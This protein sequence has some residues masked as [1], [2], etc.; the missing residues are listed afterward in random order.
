MESIAKKYAF[1]L[2]T[3]TVKPLKEKTFTC[4]NTDTIKLE[5][6]VME[7][8]DYKYLDEFETKVEV[9]YSYP[10]G[11]IE[12]PIKQTMDEGGIEII[13]DS[14]ITIVPAE[15]CLFPTDYLRI[16]INVYNE[17]EFISLQPFIFRVSKSKEG[18]IFDEAQDVL[19]NVNDIRKEMLA[20]NEKMEELTNYVNDTLAQIDVY[21]E[22]NT[23]NMISVI[24]EANT[25]I[26]ECT[27]RANTLNSDLDNYFLRN[28]V[29]T[30]T[31][32]DG[33]ITFVTNI[34]ED[35][36]PFNLINKSYI[37]TV[38]GSVY[39]PDIITTGIHTI[40]FTLDGDK[41][42]VNYVILANKSI[43]GKS[44]SI[45]PKFSNGLATIEKDA[46]G[47]NLCIQTNILTSYVDT[48][49]CTLTSTSN[50]ISNN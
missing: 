42:G 29:L 27:E 18:E 36:T 25:K 37:L 41:I 15:G 20:L 31:D 4:Y 38:S 24:E 10:N 11:E 33:K 22:E 8:E 6:E 3:R 30:P 50:H 7:E 47:F 5:I 26:D 1:T 44:L 13:P 23:S 49:S 16:D 46:T 2:E 14:T 17:E 39:V 40:Y 35:V 28:I 48:A 9:I 32:V 19:Q 21:I 34:A 43:Q 45:T 12:R